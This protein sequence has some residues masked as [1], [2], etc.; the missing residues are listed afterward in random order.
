MES[1]LV[2]T[3]VVVGRGLKASCRVRV[4]VLTGL[5]F[6]DSPCTECAIEEGPPEVP[7]GFYEL[8]FLN[9]AASIRREDGQW[10][11]GTPWEAAT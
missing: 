9:Q 4:H 11:E 3:G 1:P 2:V 5:F 7:D 6:A 8:R 10:T